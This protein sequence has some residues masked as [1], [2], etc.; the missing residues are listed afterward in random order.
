MMRS[1]SPLGNLSRRRGLVTISK[2]SAAQAQ[3]IIVVT[4]PASDPPR[5]RKNSLLMSSS[6]SA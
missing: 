3:L 1:R 4:A 6:T 2:D 5:P